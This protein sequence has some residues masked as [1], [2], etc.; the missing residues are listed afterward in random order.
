MATAGAAGL[1]TPCTLIL[2]HDTATAG[3]GSAA[4]PAQ[5][6]S[7]IGRTRELAVL[8]QMLGSV[9]L[10]TLTGAGGSGKTRL[11]L[12]A[13]GQVAPEYPH[14]AAWAELAAV[15]DP[16]LL[17][18]QVAMTLG[19]RDDAERSTTEALLEFLSRRR[20]LLVLDNCEHLADA[21][22]ALSDTL[23]RGCPG[24]TILATSRE[25]LGVMGERAWLVP[26]LTLPRDEAGGRPEYLAGFE[27]VQLFSERARDV[28]HTFVLTEQN[29]AAVAQICRRLDGIP[30]ALELAAARVK[31]LAPE[32]IA[33][34]LD[35]VFSLLTSGSRT[36]LPR[37]RT[38][39][40]TIDW[41]YRLLSRPE[42]SLLQSLSVFAGGF[43][44]EAV[45]AVCAQEAAAAWEVL[46]LV[47]RLVDRSLVVVSERDG[48]ARY[49][50]L[51]TVAQYARE[52]LRESGAEQDT[53]RRHAEYYLGL[54]VEAEPHVIL[55]RTRWMERVDAE[56]DNFR[57]ALAWSHATGNDERIGLRLATAL[58]WY[59][60]H[61]IHWREG[62]RLLDSALAGAPAATAAARA[63][64]LH[65]TGV[66]ALYIGD[67]DLAERR[68]RE[69]EGIWR[70]T[71]NERWLAF[72]L[73]CLTT[74]ALTSGRP[75]AAEAHAEEC[76]QAARATGQAWDVAL[77]S[78][79]PAMAVRMWRK[80]WTGAD[81]HLAEAERVFRDC[82]Y[83]YGLAFV[84]DARAFV[85]LQRDDLAQAQDLARLALRELGGR[86][87]EWLASR[88]L[89]ILGFAAAR[90]DAMEESVRLLAASDALL[91]S[92]GARGLAGEREHMDEVLQQARDQLS[93]ADFHRAWGEGAAMDFRQAL[94]HAGAAADRH[95]TPIA[96]VTDGAV[97]PAG[98]GAAQDTIP[99]SSPAPAPAEPRAVSRPDPRSPRTDLRVLALGP[100]RIFRAGE[101]LREGA[102]PY[103]RPRE[104]LLF[105]LAHPPGRTREQI[106]A[107]FWPESSSAKVKNSFHV[108]LHHLRKVLGASDWVVQDNERY[109]V[110]PELRLEFDAAMF[111]ELITDALRQARAGH[112]S[113]QQ[114]RTALALY[115]GDFMEG[116]GARDWHLELR[117]HLH[118]LY[119][120]GLSALGEILLEEEDFTAAAETC[121]IILGRENLREDTHRRLMLCLSRT[122]ERA[123]AL[124][125][126]ERLLTLLRE[127][128]GAEPE[129]ETVLLYERLR[130]A[131]P[132]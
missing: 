2:M 52:Q 25:A 109:R 100:L 4:L 7:F 69:A 89:R 102:W 84:L 87:D 10:L 66:F 8:R 19:L 57:A 60:Y 130:Q 128:L 123:R 20:L 67:L 39:R 113:A 30:L 31:V 3:H 63:G 126:F 118:R 68:L 37:H 59:W 21:A 24:L 116:E 88:S 73:S 79:Y 17:P 46:D 106:G 131:E 23:L 15:S 83:A 18:Q 55:D 35:N 56:H 99:D 51:D 16:A 117:D 127:E 119:I 40:A 41:S 122:G 32:Q 22:A 9:R 49:H 92:V 129:T 72:T 94:A 85:A 36:A 42:Q 108:T 75:D 107:E 65:G 111:Q 14:G 47:A 50:L 110:N 132:A 34:R 96:A 125:H 74:V 103:A 82:G 44:L 6:T 124:R 78:G 29:S 112:G 1:G 81:L 76:L 5:L 28:L 90:S 12:E 105:L 53:Q 64:A 38:L 71:G 13:A 121:R 77:A 93:A 120:D 95:D 101:L 43:T 98:A 97:G 54:A 26:P 80:D 91:A 58:I 33:E 45:E 104:L 61:R 48:S 86:R 70:A 27:A 115:R 62:F 114:L 11:A